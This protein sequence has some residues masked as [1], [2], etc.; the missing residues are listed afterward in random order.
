[1]AAFD[2]VEFLLEDPS[3][4]GLFQSSAHVNWLVV[5]EA[6]AYGAEVMCY[7]NCVSLLWRKVA[8]ADG[9]KPRLHSIGLFA[10]ISVLLILDVLIVGS[11]ALAVQSILVTIYMV[12]LSLEIYHT[13]LDYHAL[14]DIR[15]CT[16][17]RS[18]TETMYT[19]LVN[20]F[21]AF[22]SAV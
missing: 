1:M 8:K 19:L 15:Q 14:W 21:Y 10:Y 12:I 6:T 22:L 7:A 18:F 16:P 9:W 4:H 17:G 3:S 11:L 5:L 2:S 13:C 20:G